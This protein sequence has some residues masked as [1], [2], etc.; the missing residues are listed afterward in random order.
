MN[1]VHKK[2][3]EIWKEDAI[4]NRKNPFKKLANSN[5]LMKLGEKLKDNMGKPREEMSAGC[6]YDCSDVELDP[7]SSDSDCAET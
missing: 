6:G 2:I 4:K 1:E 3:K 5:Y 7:S